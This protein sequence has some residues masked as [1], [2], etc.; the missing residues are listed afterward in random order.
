VKSHLNEANMAIIDE[1]LK[2]A[3]ELSTTPS[4]VALAWLQ[5]KP[6]VASSIIGART[7]KQLEDNLEALDLTLPPQWLDKLDAV[8]KPTLNFPFDF[9]QNSG[10]FGMGGT[11][12]NG[13][14]SPVF[15]LAPQSDAERYEGAPAA[16]RR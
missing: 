1:L 9:V 13:M 15:S 16:V 4:R 5:A 11:T 7:L 8:S 6:G 12:I 3:R 14:T 10:P 2:A